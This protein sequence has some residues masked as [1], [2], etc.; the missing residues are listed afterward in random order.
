MSI[1][2]KNIMLRK[3]GMWAL[4]CFV[5]SFLF[6]DKIRIPSWSYL[7]SCGLYPWAVL[8][9]CIL[10]L[11]NKRGK[12]IKKMRVESEKSADLPHILGGMLVLAVSLSMPRDIGLA[13]IVFEMLLAYLGIFIIFFGRAAILPGVLLGIYGFSVGFPAAVAR[14]M[15]MQY[16]LATVWMVVTSLKTTGFQLTS[17]GQIIGFPNAG[18]DELS[19]FV[20]A[21]CSGSAS[22]TIFIAIFA[23]MMLD[24]RLPNRGALYMLVFGVVGT[25]VQNVIRIIIIILAGYYYDYHGIS[26]AHAYA[27]YILFPAWFLLFAYVYF[28]YAKKLSKN[29]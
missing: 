21:A 20:N 18:G 24:I 11:Y 27:G 19:V 6:L 13:G 12:Q 5:I 16:S 25:T 14:Y 1:D 29:T 7:Q 22:M 9:L 15:D 26:V 10:W 28:M 8:L 17:Q 2:T 23:L 4:S 3:L